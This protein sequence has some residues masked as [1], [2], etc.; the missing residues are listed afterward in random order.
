MKKQDP[1]IFDEL[2]NPLLKYLVLPMVAAMAMGM[3]GTVC[4]AAL[5]GCHSA[6]D[7]PGFVQ[8]LEVDVPSVL[9][10]D[11]PAKAEVSVIVPIDGQERTVTV[12]VPGGGLA[13]VPV[14]RGK[15]RIVAPWGVSWHLHAGL[16]EVNGADPVAWLRGR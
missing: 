12:A 8:P 14:P 15:V 9:V 11:S 4:G 7:R 13:H 1:D 16:E 10:F 6:S 5:S 3:V 2:I